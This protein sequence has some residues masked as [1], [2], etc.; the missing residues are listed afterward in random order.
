MALIPQQSWKYQKLRLHNE[1]YNL[2]IT[3]PQLISKQYAIINLKPSINSILVLFLVK[4]LSEV[5]TWNN[6][7]IV[8]KNLLP[9]FPEDYEGYNRFYVF[10]KLLE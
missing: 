10:L 2:Y 3:A 6:A 1:V 4:I 7:I 9:Y 8:I 5:I